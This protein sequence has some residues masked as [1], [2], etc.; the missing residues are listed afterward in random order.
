MRQGLGIALLVLGVLAGMSAASMAMKAE[1]QRLPPAERVGQAIGGS[2]CSLT[3]I[4]GGFFLI[5][6]GAKQTSQDIRRNPR[7]RPES[8]DDDYDDDDDRPR[9]SGRRRRRAARDEEPEDF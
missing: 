7:R 8:D 5:R 6:S 2:L 1:A 4:V 9:R 3:P